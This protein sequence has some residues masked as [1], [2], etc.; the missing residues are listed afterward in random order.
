MNEPYEFPLPVWEDLVQDF[1]EM[2]C[3]LTP[4]ERDFLIEKL[5][6]EQ[7]LPDSLRVYPS[8]IIGDRLIV[9]CEDGFA[10]ECWIYYPKEKRVEKSRLEV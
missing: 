8:F 1:L 3:F 9:V 10:S 5:Q 4:S 6:Q 7:T 2:A